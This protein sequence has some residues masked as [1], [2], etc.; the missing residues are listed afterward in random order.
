[1]WYLNTKHWTMGWHL[2]CLYG[3]NLIHPDFLELF[4]R[5]LGDFRWDC[6]FIGRDVKFVFNLDSDKVRGNP[7]TY[8]YARDKCLE[9]MCTV[10]LVDIWRERNP[11]QKSFTWSSN[12]ISGIHCKLVF[13]SSSRSL[14]HSVVRNNFTSAYAHTTPLLT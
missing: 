13:F 9:I 5:K 7:C 6:L 2:W 4:L 8:F 12:I 1:M 3:P 11:H 14:T 10:N